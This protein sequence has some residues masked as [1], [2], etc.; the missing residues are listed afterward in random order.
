MQWGGAV[1]EGEFTVDRAAE[2]ASAGFP[3]GLGFDMTVPVADLEV[4][5]H[6]IDVYV[7]AADGTEIKVVKDRTSAGGNIN[8]VGVTFTVSAD[9]TPT[10]PS[11]ETT[12]PD[13][14][15]AGDDTPDNPGTSDTAV[16]ALASVAAVALAGAFIGKK[17][18]KK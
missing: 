13:D 9:E 6:S 5:E 15:T 14:T 8:Q 4:G 18:L 12:V 2:L 1:V 7:I 17:A 11:D 10:E 16:I 3:G